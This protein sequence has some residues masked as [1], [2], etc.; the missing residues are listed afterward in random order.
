MGRGEDCGFV[1]K[2]LGGHPTAPKHDVKY[3]HVAHAYVLLSPCTDPPNTGPNLEAVSEVIHGRSHDMNY[4]RRVLAAILEHR[5][6]TAE[7]RC[8]NKDRVSSKLIP[9]DVVVRIDEPNCVVFT[10]PFT[11]LNPVNVTWLQFGQ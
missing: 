4:Y 3:A 7:M 2:L 8:L 5:E 9:I 6:P 11:Q 1:S 10:E